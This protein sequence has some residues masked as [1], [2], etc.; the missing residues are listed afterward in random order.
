MVFLLDFVGVRVFYWS[1]EI[2]VFRVLLPYFPD[3]SFDSLFRAW[4]SYLIPCSRCVCLF[5]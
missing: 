4:I 3:F 5:A 2:F 1:E